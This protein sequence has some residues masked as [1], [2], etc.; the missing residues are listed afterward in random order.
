MGGPSLPSPRIKKGTITK[1][2]EGLNA[3]L[4]Q[5]TPHFHVARSQPLEREGE[6]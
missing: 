6:A 3:F 2:A 4:K 5:L 1:T